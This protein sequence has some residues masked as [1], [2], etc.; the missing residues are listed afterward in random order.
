MD[1]WTSSLAGLYRVVSIVRP[2]SIS[3]AGGRSAL[4]L[5]R[6][7]ELERFYLLLLVG[8]SDL[9][10]WMLLGLLY[11]LSQLG[12]LFY[13]QVGQ[14]SQGR[15]LIRL[16]GVPIDSIG[17]L[18]GASISELLGLLLGR[19]GSDVAR[20]IAIGRLRALTMS[21]LSLIVI[22]L[23]VLRGVFAGAGIIN[24]SFLLDLLSDEYRRLVLSLLT[25]Q[26]SR[27]VRGTRRAL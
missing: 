4:G 27:H 24:L 11:V 5:S 10:L 13:G 6:L 21:G 19:L 16:C 22:R 8:R 18:K 7:L 3:C 2:L 14:G 25:L 23:I 17:F 26:C 1:L 15:G 20:I 12:V 9:F